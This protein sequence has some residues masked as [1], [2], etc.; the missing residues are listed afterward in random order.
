MILTVQQDEGGQRLDRYIADHLADY[1]R[2][3]AG[4][5]VRRGA[6]Q[7]D[8]K[9]VRPAHTVR[10]GERIEIVRPEPE[11]CTLQGEPIP[12]DVL[13]E[14]SDIIVVNK[15]AG[16][17]VHPAPGN[18]NGTLVNALVHR[19][20]DDPPLIGGGLRP[21]IVHRLDKDTSG[22]MVVA[23]TDRAYQN[24]VEQIRGRSAIRE[25]VALV[26]GTIREHNGE[27]DAPVGRS[28]ADRKR[29]AVTGVRSRSALTRF[30]VLERFS[31]VTFVRVW[32]QTGRTHQI[33]VH[34]AYIG[35][36]VVGDK[37]YKRGRSDA[38]EMLRR[39]GVEL[40]RQALHA[41]RLS[42]AH[43]VTGEAMQFDAPM[44]EDFRAAVDVLRAG[45]AEHP[46]QT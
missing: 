39:A 5:L 41:A 14:D 3:R 15:R 24:L 11:P 32:L 17:V 10:A 9:P 33:R 18:P 6:V 45:C 13:F 34:M 4:K 21:G 42:I 43:P 37:T 25:Y 12:L 29:M 30:E 22:V 31:S 8:G 2:S 44:P 27:I 28:I 7:V 1:T 19:W 40:G 20:R 36:P 16:M 35:H 26:K 46:A 38:M 23:R